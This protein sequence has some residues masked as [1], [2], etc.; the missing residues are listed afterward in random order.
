MRPRHRR[1]VANMHEIDLRLRCVMCATTM[2][3]GSQWDL[4]KPLDI[5]CARCATHYLIYILPPPQE[6]LDKSAEEA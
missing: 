1:T 5:T 4:V 6:G 2:Q 3:F